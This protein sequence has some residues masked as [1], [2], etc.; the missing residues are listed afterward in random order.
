MNKELR[1]LIEADLP[2]KQRIARRWYLGGA[3]VSSIYFIVFA[4][5]L[6]QVQP[7]QMPHLTLGLCSGAIFFY[8]LQVL[9]LQ[10]RQDVLI[11]QVAK[12]V[13]NF[14]EVKK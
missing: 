9:Y 3:I 13:Y 1:K 12:K 4:V 8:F 2:K 11:E 6:L 7:L 5:S 14:V 10:L